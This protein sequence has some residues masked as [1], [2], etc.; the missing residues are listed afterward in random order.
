MNVH[1]ASN[2]LT[3]ETVARAFG[4]LGAVLLLRFKVNS[5]WLVLAGALLGLAAHGLGIAH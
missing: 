1:S 5:T 4:I 3:S 2:A